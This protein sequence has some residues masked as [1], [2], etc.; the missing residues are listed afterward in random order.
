MTKS[1]YAGKITA[2]I[3]EQTGGTF[4]YPDTFDSDVDAH[5]LQRTDTEAAARL[6]WIEWNGCDIT[7][8]HKSSIPGARWCKPNGW[9]PQ[10]QVEGAEFTD[11][12]W[13]GQQGEEAGLVCFVEGEEGELKCVT[14]E[15]L[16]VASCGDCRIV[17]KVQF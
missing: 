7:L 13:W 2:I 9:E 6:L 17:G 14:A 16:R 4:E 8:G 5:F 12:S 11:G 3:D 1:H 15:D 10:N